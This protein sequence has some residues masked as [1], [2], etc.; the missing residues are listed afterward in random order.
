M[1]GVGRN[2]VNVLNSFDVTA[3]ALARDRALRRAK[4]TEWRSLKQA[5]PLAAMPTTGKPSR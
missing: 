4:V 1:L 3:L 2:G 5:S